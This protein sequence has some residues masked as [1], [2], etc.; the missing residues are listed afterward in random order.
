MID[1]EEKL[2]QEAYEEVQNS[3]VDYKQKLQEVED[4]FVQKGWKTHL[5]N[6]EG[7]VFK[8]EEDA[9]Y[10][11]FFYYWAEKKTIQ[12]YA[13][14]EMPWTEKKSTFTIPLAQAHDGSINTS[15]NETEYSAPLDSD[16]NEEVDTVID[17]VMSFNLPEGP[18]SNEIND[19][20]Y[21]SKGDQQ[22]DLEK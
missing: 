22:R 11:I 2:L 15:E 3:S 13:N 1:Q 6:N 16:L 4:L 12:F 7:I 5:G 20:K 9:Q 14:V 10:D 21:Y 19:H 8:K 17:Q 18:T